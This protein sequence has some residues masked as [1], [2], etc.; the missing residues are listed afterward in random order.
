MCDWFRNSNTEYIW[1]SCG[2]ASACI[3]G[4][5]FV[6]EQINILMSLNSYKILIWPSSLVIVCSSGVD[7]FFLTCPCQKFNKTV[8][9]S[10]IRKSRE[11]P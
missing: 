5:W 3:L 10:V 1:V 4:S 6:T 2:F 9:G 7:K 11:A 8:E